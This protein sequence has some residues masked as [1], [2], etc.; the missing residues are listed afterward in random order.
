MIAETA[1]QLLT[2]D[3]TKVSESRMATVLR[4]AA[5]KRDLAP[6]EAYHLNFTQPMSSLAYIETSNLFTGYC[7]AVF[8]PDDDVEPRGYYASHSDLFTL[9]SEDYEQMAAHIES[10][11]AKLAGDMLDD[12]V[13]KAQ[14]VEVLPLM[15]PCLAFFRGSVLDYLRLARVIGRR[16]QVDAHPDTRDLVETVV[17]ELTANHRAVVD[18]LT[19]GSAI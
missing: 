3:L 16:T 17:A 1:Y 2:G 12:G 4:D 11:A 15:T 8:T 14:A 6:F 19:E 10:Q 18:A 5:K 9:D 7:R 13:N